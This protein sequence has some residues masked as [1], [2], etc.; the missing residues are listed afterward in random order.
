MRTTS[1]LANQTQI[2]L[3]FGKMLESLNSRE[4]RRMSHAGLGHVFGVIFN[5]ALLGQLA[6]AGDVIRDMFGPQAA[7]EFKAGGGGHLDI[8]AGDEAKTIHTDFNLTINR[9]VL[10]AGRRTIRQTITEPASREQVMAQLVAKDE[11]HLLHRE[12]LD[13]AG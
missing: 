11:C 8:L 7:F 10:H 12:T 13:H 6:E 3:G 5:E 9:C 1:L 4:H 2:F